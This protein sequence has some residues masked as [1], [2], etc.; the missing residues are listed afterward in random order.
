VSSPPSPSQLVSVHNCAPLKLITQVGKVA[1]VSKNHNPFARQ[2]NVF[3]LPALWKSQELLGEINGSFRLASHK[4]L[5]RNILGNLFLPRAL[6]NMP[7]L[8]GHEAFS[9]VTGG[10]PLSFSRR[11]N[12]GNRSPELVEGNAEGGKTPLLIRR[13][14]DQAGSLGTKEKTLWPSHTPVCFAQWGK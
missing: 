7:Y 4:G 13:R 11:I 12:G 2:G 1:L 6:I 3:H 10:R 8:D 5:K 9:V 14:K